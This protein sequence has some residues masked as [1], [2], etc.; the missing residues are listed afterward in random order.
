MR[1]KYDVPVGYSGHEPNIIPSVMAANMGAVILERH[2]TID[3]NMA[4]LDHAAS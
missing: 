2:I 4:G 3:K 1:E